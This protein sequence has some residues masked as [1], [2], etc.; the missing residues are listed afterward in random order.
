MYLY[1]NPTCYYAKM[2]KQNIGTD[3]I[4]PDPDATWPKSLGSDRIRIHN[5]VRMPRT[6]KTLKFQLAR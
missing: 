3:A 4:I 5:T 2:F 1:V 6:Q